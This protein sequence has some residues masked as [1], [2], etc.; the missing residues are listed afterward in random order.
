MSQQSNRLDDLLARNMKYQQT[1]TPPPSLAAIKA[2][3]PPSPVGI[4]IVSCADPRV[5]PENFMGFSVG[6]CAVIRNTGGRAANALPSILILDSVIPMQAVAIVHHTDC[7][8]THVTEASMRAHL[9]KLAPG[10]TEAISKMDFQIFEA[11]TLE[12]SVVEDMRL[13]RASPY[14]RKEMPVRGFVLDIETGVLKEI[15]ADKVGV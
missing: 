5:I 11:A 2:S 10:H 6:E 3:L 7:G 9:S 15:E 4:A 12:A 13:V 8:V 14:I 1:Y